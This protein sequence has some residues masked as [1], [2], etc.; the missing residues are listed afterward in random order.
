MV[1]RGNDVRGE[2]VAKWLLLIYGEVRPFAK[3]G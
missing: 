1:F 2:A 3:K